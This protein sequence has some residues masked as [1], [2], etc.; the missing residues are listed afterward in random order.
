MNYKILH[1]VQNDTRRAQNDNR[2][3]FRIVRQPASHR[4]FLQGKYGKL[5]YEVELFFKKEFIMGKIGEFE[6][7]VVAEPLK[8]PLPAK[9][10]QEVP[11]EPLK[12]AEP[13]EVSP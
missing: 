2:P 11:G 8:E 10:P 6:K 12:E 1:F 13:V 5:K 4:T 7:T 9:M 3:I